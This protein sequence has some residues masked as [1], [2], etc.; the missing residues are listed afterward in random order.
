MAHVTFSDGTVWLTVALTFVAM[1]GIDVAAK[2][3]VRTAPRP[4]PRPAVLA[5]RFA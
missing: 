4:P 1:T 5:Q 3:A 2:Y